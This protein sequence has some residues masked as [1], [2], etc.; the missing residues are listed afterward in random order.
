MSDFIAEKMWPDARVERS[1]F[2][3]D[4]PETI[5]AQVLEVC[6]E[7]ATCFAPVRR[8]VPLAP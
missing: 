7:A 6:P 1:I 8:N 2:G 5:W 3:T 4:D